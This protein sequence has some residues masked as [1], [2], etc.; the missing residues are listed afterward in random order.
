M[1]CS[2]LGAVFGAAFLASQRG[3]AALPKIIAGVA[4]LI[5]IAVGLF[6][7]STTLW[8]AAPA[9][10]LAGFAAITSFV[11]CN[12]LIQTL[13]PDSL[14]GRVMSLY[15]M[16]LVGISPLGS[17]VAGA[18]GPPLRRARDRWARARC[19]SSSSRS[20]SGAICAAAQAHGQTEIAVE[21]SLAAD[22]ADCADKADLLEDRRP[23]RRRL[24]P[25]KHRILI[26]I[27]QC[28]PRRSH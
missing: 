7:F 13:V 28:N 4:P 18:S 12:T 1:A 15:S 3:S 14:R 6:G 11:A 22:L 21:L 16:C 23:P 10:T 5:G 17:L 26:R 25:R 19:W 20:T 27:H 2:G 8:F 24:R 9:L